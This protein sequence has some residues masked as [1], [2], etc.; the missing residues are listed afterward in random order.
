MKSNKLVLKSSIRN[1]LKKVKIISKKKPMLNEKFIDMLTR[2]EN[3]MKMK[4]EPFRALLIKKQK[5][6]LWHI[7]LL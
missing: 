3:I 6:Q 4:G 1:K 5:K 7:L 2:L